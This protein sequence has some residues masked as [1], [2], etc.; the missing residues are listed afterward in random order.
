MPTRTIAQ[1]F[2]KFYA[3]ITPHSYKEGKAKSHKDSIESKLKNNFHLSQFSDSGLD[4]NGA[5]ISKYSDADV[6]SS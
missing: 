5:S 2:D 4:N 6:Y 1:G 3:N